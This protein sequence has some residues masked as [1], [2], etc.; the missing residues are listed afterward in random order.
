MDENR[1]AEIEEMA[2]SNRD[3]MNN[4]DLGVEALEL[5]AEIRAS[6]TA[7]TELADEWER[8]GCDSFDRWAFDRLRALAD[9]STAAV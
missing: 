4:H 2:V 1:L 9:R 3:Y 8:E 6:R 7:I 5:V